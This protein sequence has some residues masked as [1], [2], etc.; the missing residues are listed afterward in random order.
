MR[1]VERFRILITFEM[2]CSF[3]EFEIS[4]SVRMIIFITRKYRSNYKICIIAS[5]FYF[6]LEEARS[7]AS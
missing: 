5:S 3:F 6:F 1:G 7:V 4:V 2:N